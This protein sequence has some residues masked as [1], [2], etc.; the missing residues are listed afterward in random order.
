MT[1]NNTTMK[2]DI[3]S[4]LKKHVDNNF[5]VTESFTKTLDQVEGVKIWNKFPYSNFT[6]SC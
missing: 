1:V 6:I 2:I 3:T 5:K 4:K